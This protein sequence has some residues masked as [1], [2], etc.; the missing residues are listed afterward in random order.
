M[1]MWRRSWLSR[2][3]VLF[4]AFAGIASTY[5]VAIWLRRPE[6]IALGGL[7][8]IVGLAGIVASACI[9]RVPSRPS[10]NSRLT[11]LRF[12]M[13]A[14]VLGSLFAIA[15]AAGDTPWLR[16]V[17]VTMAIGQALVV[18]W[19]YLRLIASDRVELRG[20]AR[21]LST[22]LSGR[23]M[24]RGALLAAGGV[25]LPLLPGG[26]A[27]AAAALAL[28]LAGELLDRYLLFVSVVPKHMTTPYL[29]MGSEAAA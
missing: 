26:A 16:A 5:A 21:L 9:Y 28:A 13:T 15:V 6:G 1:K 10:W 12:A 8:A 7:T 4:G 23:F 25:V 27:V 11:V 14:A 17:A 22:A 18:S 19:S 24:L 3:V 2:E 20:T 29:P